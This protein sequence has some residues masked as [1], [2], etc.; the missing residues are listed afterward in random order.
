MNH[1]IS[2]KA[3]ELQNLFSTLGTK[4]LEVNRQEHIIKMLEENNER[5]Q[6]LRV[7]QED[8]IA[9]LENENAELK[10]L[11]WVFDEALI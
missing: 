9:R 8:R 5:N 2:A 4:Q 7:K 10:H 3:E 11:L 6:R 1:E